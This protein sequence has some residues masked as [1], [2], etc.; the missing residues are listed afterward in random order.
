MTDVTESA[1]HREMFTLPPLRE[2]AESLPSAYEK[3]A[4]EVVTG[5]KEVD[6]VLWLHKVIQSGEP[7]AIERAKEAAKFIKTPLKD[8]EKRYTQYLNRANPGNPFASFASIGFADLDSMAEKAIKR[9]NLQIEAASRFG[10]DLMHETPAENFCIEALAGLEPGWI[11]LFEGEE[12]T[13]RF[14][15]RRSMVPSSLSEC[16]HELRYWDK[17]YAMRHACEWMY[18]HHSE[19]CAREDF[20]VG[21]L[22]SITPKDRA[23]AREVYQYVL[24]NGDKCG[25][26][27][28]AI[29]WNLIG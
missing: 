1:A 27:R 18:E 11:G 20:L 23:E 9:R 25:D 12:V 8:L 14:S 17:L 21:L 19:V 4:E 2:S 7:A 26:G 10:D 16:L 28:S 24:D 5:D 15:A 13:E 29:I 22:A 6:A 3:P